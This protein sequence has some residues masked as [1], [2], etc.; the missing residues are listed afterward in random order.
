MHGRRVV[1][2]NI[3]SHG[4]FTVRSNYFARRTECSGGGAA[5]QRE[6]G[7]RE[8]NGQKKRKA[9]RRRRS[10]FCPE[11]TDAATPRRRPGPCLRRASLVCTR[12]RFPA[13]G[14]PRRAALVG[15]ASNHSDSLAGMLRHLPQTRARRHVAPP[16]RAHAPTAHVPAVLLWVPAVLCVCVCARAEY[17]P[18]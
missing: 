8:K 5:K 17:Q 16:C 4:I 18:A 11:C 12:R 9:P 2:P 7:P 15:L 14:T 10:Y 3:K 6:T 1:D 13:N